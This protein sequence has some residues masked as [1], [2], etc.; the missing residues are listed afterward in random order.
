MTAHEPEFRSSLIDVSGVP[1]I[2]LGDISD[3]RLLLH[4]RP[5][6]AATSIDH[7]RLWSQDNPFG[8]ADAE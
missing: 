4:V 6:L 8:P 3:R 2:E 1:L 7:D 5:L